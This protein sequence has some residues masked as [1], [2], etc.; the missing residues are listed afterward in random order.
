MITQKLYENDS[1]VKE[2]DAVVTDCVPA[3]QIFGSEMALPK[4]GAPDQ[5]G[6]KAGAWAVELDRTAF[7]PEGGG[8]SADTGWLGGGRVYDVQIVDGRLW[9]CT[10]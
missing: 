2:F 7:F 3:Q 9:H 4:A 6:G 8:Q 5:A 10:D 1:Y